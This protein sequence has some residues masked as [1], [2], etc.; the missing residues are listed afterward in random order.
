[1][2]ICTKYGVSISPKEAEMGKWSADRLA[3]T[4]GAL[5]VVLF[6]IA[7]FTATQPPDST[8]GNAEWVS[9]YLN[10]HRSTLASAILIGV[11]VMTYAWFAGSVG[12][13]LR[14]AGER[15]LGLVAFGGGV[16][17][18][19]TGLVL[20]GV[21][22]AL[23]YGIAL[24]SPST[25]KAFV[26][27]YLALGALIAFPIALT[28]GASAI[29][30]FRSGAFPRWWAWLSGAAALVMISG[31]AT[32]AHSGFYRPDGPW[33]FIVLIVFLAWTLLTS[34]WLAFKT[35]AEPVREAAAAA[36]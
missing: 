35:L 9:Y 23:S 34:C 31:G 14:D 16:A 2:A 1:V 15:R 33:S 24:D 27:V 20:G 25:V 12:A 7:F 4:S 26:D 13:A 3:A 10:H 30:A 36:G 11:A 28:I 32:L 22:A 6:L 21:A 19:T 17:T 5:F 8:D 18:A 29:A